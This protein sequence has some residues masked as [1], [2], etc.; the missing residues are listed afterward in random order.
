[1]T[2]ERGEL[3]SVKLASSGLNKS[4]KKRSAKVSAEQREILWLK[5][6]TKYTIQ[7]ADV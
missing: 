3:K 7:T 1:M 6:V 2:V 4:A 5:C